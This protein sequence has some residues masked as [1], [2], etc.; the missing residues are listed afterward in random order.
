MI[1]LKNSTFV[2]NSYLNVVTIDFI[3]PNQIINREMLRI[4]EK[5][6]QS[7]ELFETKTLG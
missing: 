7:E 3:N 2:G 5:Y 1:L 4:L 6:T